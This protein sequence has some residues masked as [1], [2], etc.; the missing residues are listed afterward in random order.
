MLGWMNRMVQTGERPGV[1]TEISN[2]AK[3]WNW[4][5]EVTTWTPEQIAAAYNE[6]T[7]PK[8]QPVQAGA[9]GQQVTSNGYPNG[10]PAY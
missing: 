5:W 10:Q 6:L 9:W 8:H 2:L 1:K 7:G 4:H 3:A